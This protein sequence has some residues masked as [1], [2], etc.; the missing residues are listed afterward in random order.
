MESGWNVWVW[1]VSVVNRRRVWL[2]TVK[3][4]ILDGIIFGVFKNVGLLV[5]I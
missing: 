4:E 2:Y 1:L 5:G 3:E